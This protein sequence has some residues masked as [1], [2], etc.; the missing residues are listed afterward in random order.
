GMAQAAAEL[1]HDRALDAV[2]GHCALHLA[3][4]RRGRRELEDRPALEVDAEVQ[5]TDEHRHDADQ[6]DGRGDRV[7]GPLPADEVVG[8]LAAVEPAADVAEARHHASPVLRDVVLRV[9]VWG[10]RLT[11]ARRTEDRHGARAP[12]RAG[13]RP[14]RGCPLPKNLVRASS[15]TIG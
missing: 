12:S 9:A 1:L 3:D 5:A 15:V 2:A 8:N 4:G 7:P 11:S 13:S 6:Q 10:L 14:E